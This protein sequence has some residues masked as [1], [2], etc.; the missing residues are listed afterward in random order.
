MLEVLTD[1]LTVTVLLSVLVAYIAYYWNFRYYAFRQ[2]ST[3]RKGKKLMGKTLPAFPNGW[4]CVAKSHELKSK[5]T[6]YI[7]QSGQNIALFRGE[8]NIAYAVDAYCSHMGANLAIGGTVKY[9]SCIQ[10]PFHGWTF[11]GAT[12]NCVTGKDKKPKIAD[13]YSYA[14]TIGDA[15]AENNHLNKEC[16]EQVKIRTWILREMNG[17]IYLWIHSMPEHKDTPLYEPFEIGEFTRKLEYRGFSMNKVDSHVQDIPENGGDLMHFFYVHSSLLPFTDI[18]KAK[19]SSKWLRGD[20][21]QLF[22]KMIHEV[23]YINE[24]RKHLFAKYLNDKNRK[25][26]GV[27]SLDSYVSFPGVKDIFFFNATAFQVGPGL[28]YLFLK[29]PFFESLFFQHVTSLE[30]F[31]HEIYHELYT[32]WYLP[33]FFSAIKIRL[34]AQQVMNDGI[35]WDNKKFA[36]SAYYNLKAEPDNMLLEWRKWFVQFYQGCKEA[37]AEKEKLEW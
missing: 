16:S 8:D 32:N 30:K 14:E 28:V 4:Y 33:Y 27:L 7:D 25:Y 22:E 26:I 31:K 34:E 3:F 17:Y 23:G 5:E 12:G 13:K 2:K 37:E 11:D 36:M 29:G 20:D 19:W 35:V 15:K 6:K 10:C 9:G 24:H 18:L 21:P 1:N